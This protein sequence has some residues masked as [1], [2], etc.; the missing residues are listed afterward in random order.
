M[1]L[2]VM[3]LKYD[4]F[5]GR[6]GRREFWRFM[7]VHVILL[8]IARILDFVVPLTQSEWYESG[9]IYPIYWVVAIVPVLA[10]GARRLHDTG[11]SGWYQALILTWLPTAVFGRVAAGFLRDGVDPTTVVLGMLAL[12]FLGAALVGTVMLVIFAIQP[13]E[14]RENRHGLPGESPDR[15]AVFWTVIA[16]RYAR[17]SGRAS[18][19]EFWLFVLVGLTVPFVAQE[20][21]QWL[22]PRSFDEGFSPILIVLLLATVIPT[23]ALLA[24]RLHDIGLAAWWL[25][26]LVPPITPI[27]FVCLTVLAILPSQEGENKHGEPAIAPA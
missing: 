16:S 3:R 15:L 26:L 27:G 23:L 14:D 12:V 22:F 6:A 17:F 11:R 21:D 5:G 4:Q 7:L 10:L 25:L 1:Y 9:P 24:R 20:L 19:R 18:R 8:M 13:G 2:R